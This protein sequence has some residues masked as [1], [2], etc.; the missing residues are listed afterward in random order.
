MFKRFRPAASFIILSLLIG[1]RAAIAGPWD[2]SDTVTV[3]TDQELRE[4]LRGRIPPGAKLLIAPGTYA[5]G[6]SID[7]PRGKEG[8]PITI[9]GA[10]PKKPPVI[11]GGGACFYIS[12]PA[13]LTLRDMVLEHATG[14]T[15]NIDDG[16]SF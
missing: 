1:V 13:H 5:G 16:G 4:A 7:E 9:G 6:L 14:N 11:A 3:S 2:N 10:D 15:V 12:N 8:K